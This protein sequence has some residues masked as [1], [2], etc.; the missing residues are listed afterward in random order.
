MAD[1]IDCAAA[2]AGQRLPDVLGP[3]L[4]PGTGPT[5][6]RAVPGSAATGFLICASATEAKL[7]FPGVLLFTLGGLLQAVLCC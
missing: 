4:H 6:L 2:N 3:W 7:L 5:Y 1:Y